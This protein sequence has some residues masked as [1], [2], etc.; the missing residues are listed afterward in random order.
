[1]KTEKV[2][3]V[4]QDRWEKF[5][6]QRR[7]GGIW[8]EL[9]EHGSVSCPDT[10]GRSNAASSGLIFNVANI[11]SNGDVSFNGL[12]E[13]LRRS[14][15]V[16]LLVKG[17]RKLSDISKLLSRF[18]ELQGD[19]PDA[20]LIC[21][22]LMLISGPRQAESIDDWYA[23]T[24][25]MAERWASSH[26]SEYTATAKDESSE[27]LHQR[28]IVHDNRNMAEKEHTQI[29]TPSPRQEFIDLE[30]EVFSRGPE[31]A[32]AYLLRMAAKLAKEHPQLK[33]S[34]KTGIA[35]AIDGGSGVAAPISP[36]KER[37][38]R[39]IEAGT[40]EAIKEVKLPPRTG[41]RLIGKFASL[42]DQRKSLPRQG[43]VQQFQA[44]LDEFHKEKSLGSF[45][46]NRDA[47]KWV[48]LIS[49]KSKIAMFY[50]K[51]SIKVMCNNGI[52]EGYFVLRRTSGNGESLS[53]TGS[54]DFRQLTALSLTDSPSY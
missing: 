13:S 39:K 23:R 48:N 1:M 2:G 45:E 3:A 54:K 34:L 46:L 8:L 17:R 12:D 25:P 7:L 21:G 35:E 14:G 26:H 6:R 33:E 5:K 32:K 18:V 53:G 47:V 4:S 19:I 36:T 49:K 51:E 27:Y 38:P 50:E 40:N 30:R 44:L 42:W 11:T 52:P 43:F 29:G 20:G 24:I 9:N 28:A 16:A 22:T 15:R 41:H 10:I 37:R 31:V